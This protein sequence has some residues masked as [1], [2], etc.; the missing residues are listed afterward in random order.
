M[1]LQQALTMLACLAIVIA[2]VVYVGT[3]ANWWG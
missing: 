1:T 2:T 3:V